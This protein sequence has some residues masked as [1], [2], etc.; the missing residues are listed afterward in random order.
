MTD[1]RLSRPITGTELLLPQ[2]KGQPNG[3]KP[4]LTL[5]QAIAE[6]TGGAAATPEPLPDQIVAKGETIPEEPELKA[7]DLLLR[8]LSTKRA[9]E[10]TGDTNFRI[11]L[12]NYI[13]NLG[14]T[15]VIKQAGCILVELDPKSTVLFSCHVDTVHNTAESNSPEPQALA[16]DPVFG[17]LFLLDKAK[18]SCLGGDDGV[19]IF[20]MLEMIKAKKPGK[21]VFHTGEER[22]G[23]G[24]KAFTAGNKLLMESIEQVVAFDRPVRVDRAPEVII[25]QGGK[26]CASVEYGE[27]LAAALNVYKF[28]EDYAI[29]TNGV[30]TDSKEYANDVP[31][32]VNLG[33]FYNQQH[34][35]NEYV[36]IIGLE[37]LVKA[38]IGIDWTKLPIRRKLPEPVQ[39]NY[40]QDF[41]GGSKGNWDTGNRHQGST[42]PTGFPKS[43]PQQPKKPVNPLSVLEEFD[44]FT[45]QDW[46]DFA[47][48]DT[49]LVVR[50]L[51][52]LHAKLRAV[53]LERDMYEQYFDLG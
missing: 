33:C 29:S 32:C 16:L 17:H 36:D 45:A 18:A 28:S 7:P 1:H 42:Q 20:I 37:R 51:V 13:K 24:A 35:P 27:A 50:S 23:I 6:A 19:G 49:D 3:Q 52:V 40:Q 53:T 48:G 5:K 47:E 25:T 34:T 8:I 21:Y 14:A 44:T 46:V 31:E 38:A 11:W 22:G 2:A 43:E 41:G 26:P 39:Y 10:S 30:Y 9:H 15:P 12:F 4:K